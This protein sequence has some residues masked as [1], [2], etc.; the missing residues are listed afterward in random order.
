[1]KKSIYN[2]KALD[3][4][5]HELANGGNLTTANYVLHTI[6]GNKSLMASK[7]L[8]ERTLKFKSYTKPLS[9]TIARS[10][11]YAIKHGFKGAI[12]E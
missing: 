2:N 5:W 11:Y 12:N 3:W 8:F 9:Q 4:Y 1:M 7:M 6:S 10:K